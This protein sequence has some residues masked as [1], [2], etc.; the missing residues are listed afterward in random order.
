MPLTPGERLGR[1]ELIER[2]GGGGMGEVYRGRDVKLG[3]EVA[4]KVLADAGD[5]DHSRRFPDEARLASSLN[6]PNIVMI[7]GIGEEGE[8]AYIAIELVRGRTLR[9]LLEAGTLPTRKVLDLAVQLA[10]ALT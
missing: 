8:V 6:H 5:A 9:Q 3:R 4:L 2:I 1:Y 7:F 10:D